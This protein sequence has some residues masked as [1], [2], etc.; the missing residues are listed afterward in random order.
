VA[1][2]DSER[3]AARGSATGGS[4]RSQADELDERR[5]R[6]RPF[7]S[8]FVRLLSFAVPLVVA[9]AVVHLVG[10][11]VPRPAG[12]LAFAAWIVSLAVIA[13][14]TIGVVDR[15]ARRLLPLGAI[16][17]V[18]LVFPDRAPSRFAIALRSGSGR[19][20]ERAVAT[21][22]SVDGYPAPQ[23][24]AELMVTL[25]AAV[26]R[27]DRLTRGHSERVRAYA[28][29]IGKQL[30]LDEASMVKLHW[31]ALV[32]DV[33]KLDVPAEILGKKGRPTADE[34]SVLQQH[35]A[36]SRRYLRGLDAWL[37]DWGR[38]ATE[39]HERFDGDGYPSGL[40]ADEIS[41]AGRIVAVAD[42]FDV[43][44][45]ARSYKKP[46]PAERA[47]A[48]LAENAGTQFDPVIV[49]AFLS[50]SL[51]DVR[52]VMGP[53]AALAQLPGLAQVPLE[54]ATA[55]F[56]PTVAALAVTALA[57]AAPVHAS[58]VGRGGPGPSA[59]AVAAS[60][61]HPGTANTGTQKRVATPIGTTPAGGSGR[62]AGPTS[63]GKGAGG[64]GF[65]APGAP[66]TT[67]AGNQGPTGP[68]TTVPSSPTT[69]PSGPATTAPSLNRPPVAVND[70]SNG[71][72]LT[73]TVTVA[74]LANDHDP[75]GNLD[76]GSL[77]IVRD[78]PVKAYQSI[79]I[80]NGAVRFT[81]PAS[82]KGSATFRYQV[83]DTR[84]A[85]AQA[86]VTLKFQL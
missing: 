35:P 13:T 73:Q 58:A 18:S 44:T 8:L 81:A 22:T 9:I 29:L 52:L 67:T 74:V 51:R 71:N 60:T 10:L 68:V 20:L 64:P 50:V 42:A 33:G 65:T 21:A 3:E 76:P 24:A 54:A 12:A 85:C 82:Y 69:T 63:G 26:S 30:D 7:V 15:L 38:A 4:A 41:L 86:E 56:G 80:V 2:T 43:M 1:S 70:T 32:H 14:M 61:I 57:L 39:H 27:H 66:P 19:A 45:S 37:G 16:L 53:L 75:D 23:E 11:V 83:C 17:K 49:R 46:H 36:A 28:D 31:G 72:V 59:V 40:R 62:A 77:S 48:E 5:W 47:R 6:P 34:W 79:D 55:A 78:P 84:G 25:I